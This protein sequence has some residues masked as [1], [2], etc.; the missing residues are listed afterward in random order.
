[1]PKK[2]CESNPEQTSVYIDGTNSPPGKFPDRFDQNCTEQRKR[3]TNHHACMR[4]IS[5]CAVDF[6]SGPESLIRDIAK[7]EFIPTWAKDRLCLFKRQEVD[8]LKSFDRHAA[9]REHRPHYNIW[10]RYHA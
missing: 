6:V 5:P 9:R 1:M 2:S 8:L 10:H 7:G 3:A 4:A